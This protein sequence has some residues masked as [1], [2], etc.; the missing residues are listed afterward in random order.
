MQSQV[1]ARLIVIR[2]IGG[3]NSPQVG[4]AEDDHMIQALASQRAD[5]TFSDTILPW[6]SRRNRPVADAHRRDATGEDVPIGPVI[7][8]HQIGRGRCPGE[9][10]GD[11]PGEPSCRRV[12][13]DLEP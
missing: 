5:Q 2:G 6:R 9:R 8:A 7:I 11:L 13:G 1:Y 10:F 3:K 4:L 12:A